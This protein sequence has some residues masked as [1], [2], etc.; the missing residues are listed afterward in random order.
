[1]IQ[2]LAAA[3]P[4]LPWTA[5]ARA[6]GRETAGLEKP[7]YISTELR[8]TVEHDV[9]VA[10]GKRQSLPQLL[11]DSIACGMRRGVEM[12]NSPPIMLDDKEAIEHAERYGWNRE[13][14]ECG[15]HFA[16]IAEEGNVSP[17]PHHNDASA[18]EDS[19]RRSARKFR[20]RARAIR[21]EYEGHPKLD[22]PPS[23][24]ESSGESLC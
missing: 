15:D 10:T 8:V 24:G 3:T 13:E 12:Q 19:A 18:A 9:L 16:V 17:C 11:D 4:S 5:H 23:C 14:V 7:E 22:C 2:H 20:I 1:M 21:R 6:N